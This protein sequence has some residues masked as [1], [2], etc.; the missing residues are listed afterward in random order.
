MSNR[1]ATESVDTEISESTRV[2]CCEGLNDSG[3]LSPQNNN[4]LVCCSNPEED[5]KRVEQIEVTVRS[6]ALEHLTLKERR[7]LLLQRCLVF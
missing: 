2:G 3:N 4:V 7:K 1:D 5:L 6:D